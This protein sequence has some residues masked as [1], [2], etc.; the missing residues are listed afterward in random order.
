[1]KRI[2]TAFGVLILGLLAPSVNAQATRTPLI[3]QQQM[4]EQHRI[5]EGIYRGELT[6]REAKQLEWQ[7]AKIKRDKRIAKSDGV[8]TRCER[9]YLQSEQAR[10]SQQIYRQKHDRQRWP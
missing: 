8:V 4:N 7:Q 5:R 1:M 3:T 10:A 9:A 6:P 2:I